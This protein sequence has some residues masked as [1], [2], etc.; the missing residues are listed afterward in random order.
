MIPLART[1]APRL[2]ATYVPAE[3]GI[4]WWGVPDIP[5][6]LERLGLPAGRPLTLR[7]AGVVDGEVKPTVI[8]TYIGDLGTA[9]PALAELPRVAGLSES[10]R[11]WRAA[12]R[13]LLGKRTSARDQALA[14]LAATLPPAG[15]AVLN[16]DET[17]IMSASALIEQFRTALATLSALSEGRVKADLR[18]YQAHGVTWLRDRAT[19]G[20]GVVLADEMGLGKTLQSISVLATRDTDRP[21]LV[22][23]PTSLIGN[24]HREIV[25]FAPSLSVLRYHGNDRELPSEIPAGTVVITSY[26]LLRSDT[27]LSERSWDVVIFDEAQQL[28]NPTAQVTK[29]AAALQATSRIAMTG[30]PVENNLDELWS[31]FS[32]TN[33]GILGARSRFRQRFVA[34]I[35]QRRSKTAAARLATLVEPHMLRRTKAQ[36]ATELPPRV[37]SSVICTLTNEQIS[38]Y[39]KA[40][41]RAFN[42]GLGAGLGRS[43][44]ILALLTELKQICNHPAQYLDQDI[45]ER[46]RSGKF[47]RA[48][49]MLAEIVDDGERALVFTQ[50]RKMGDLL[51]AG[52][53]AAIDAGPV[54]F[55][56]GGLAA[57]KRD[58]LVRA[59]QED[60]D[61]PPILILSLRAAGFGLNLTRASNVLHFDRW[62]NPAVEE[63]ATARAHRIGQQRTLNVYTLI[64]GGTVEDHIER[65]HQEKQGIA[66]I[67]TGDPVAALSKLPDKQLREVLDLDLKGLA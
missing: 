33:P 14:A 29:A 62:W 21:H 11:G 61:A 22:V 26:P 45:P 40:V 57:H 42:T 52:L 64:A 55:L 46:G 3:N 43:G 15:H 65:M 49:E 16:A 28:K 38:L 7:L 10:A 8:E 31:I 32:V 63:Q 66:E 56:H 23:C 25:R 67:I 17:A 20:E 1:A 39:Q 24:W 13:N 6:S 58:E 51:S 50:Y 27:V 9:A 34:P 44:R 48:A 53:G 30:T 2:Q 4:A 18:P 19:S 47:D 5:V 41:D 60:D 59:F 37:D 35:Q 54:P 12:S 36:V